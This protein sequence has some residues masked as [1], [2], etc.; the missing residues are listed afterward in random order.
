MD[1][2]GWAGGLCLPGMPPLAALPVAE[3][4]HGTN[5][6]SPPLQCKLTGKWVN[7][8]G[9][10][11]TIGPVDQEG[12]FEGSYL[13]AV[14][15]TPGNICRSPLVGFQQKPNTCGQNITFGFTVNWSFSGASPSSASLQCLQNSPTLPMMSQMVPCLS[16]NVA[17]GLLYYLL[18]LPWSHALLLLSPDLPCN[19]PTIPGSSL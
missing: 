1:G 3:L 16:C 17:H 6:E 13:T 11:M 9:S 8:L 10:S 15:D 19:V 7:D 5:T 12:E 14:K 18:C 4:C 2:A